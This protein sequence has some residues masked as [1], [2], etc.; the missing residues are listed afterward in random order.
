MPLFTTH[1]VPPPILEGL[2]ATAVGGAAVVLEWFPTTLAAE[3]FVDYRVYRS[4]T[5]EATDYT[6]LAVHTDAAEVTFA[7]YAAPLDR[8][9]FYRV[10]QSNLDYESDPA[11]VE[12]ALEGCAW[13]LVTPGAPEASFEV[14]NVTGLESEWP[15]PSEE[16]TPLGR[17]RKL[18]ESGLL[19]G[20]EG[21]ATAHL[22]PEHHPAVLDLLRAA[23]AGTSAGLL[24]KT[25]YGEVFAVAVGTIARTRLPGGAQEVTFRYV[26]V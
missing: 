17:S 12:T 11:E 2:T 16:F 20:E 8:P 7:D 23:A 1:F 15:L 9:V 18:V 10:T 13:W 21:T 19:L 6:L 3:D 14:P 5:G 26:E 4:L 24:L 22:E 25:P